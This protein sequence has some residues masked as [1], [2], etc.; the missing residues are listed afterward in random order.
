LT[1]LFIWFPIIFSISSKNVYSRGLIFE[2]YVF[3]YFIS[4]IYLLIQTLLAIRY[5]Q[6]N[7]RLIPFI[8][9]CFVGLGSLVQ[10][11]NPS[12]HISWICVSFSISLY[13]IYY[14]ELLNQVDSLTG[15]LNRHSYEHNISR[16]KNNKKVSI[17]F[18]DIDNFKKI[19]DNYGHSFGDYC[20]IEVSSCIKKT[21]FK[22][23]LCFR[24]G[25]DE[26]CVISK[27]ANKK[28]IEK[29]YNDFLTEIEKKRCI[30]NNL[31][32][33]SIGYSFTENKC[34]DISDII[35]KADQNMYKFK[36]ERKNHSI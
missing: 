15:L 31:P 24:I 33:V 6:N 16:I 5:Y 1:F 12:L 30:E 36:R 14:C 35:F 28:S 4:L 8:I 18:F 10:V 11:I 20:L 34:N 2:F 32:M 17:F 19:N 3:S 23:G 26:F 9:F 13:Y 25:G 21:F 29:M 27:I 7:N 22:R